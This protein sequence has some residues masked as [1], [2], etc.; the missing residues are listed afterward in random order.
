MNERARVCVSVHVKLVSGEDLALSAVYKPASAR[1]SSAALSAA[2]RHLH[3]VSMMISSSQTQD[4][5][6]WCIIPDQLC[7]DSPADHI[8]PF[9][10]P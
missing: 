3:T 5:H 2:T 8:D 1:V 6:T 10:F 9:F 4:H 7:S